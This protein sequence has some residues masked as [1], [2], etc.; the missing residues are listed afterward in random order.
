MGAL[1]VLQSQDIMLEIL[2]WFP[3]PLYAIQK[4]VQIMA[5]HYIWSLFD[6]DQIKS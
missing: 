6:E 5:L 2:S 1:A 4:F 3:P